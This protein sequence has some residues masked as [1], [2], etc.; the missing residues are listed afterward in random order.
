MSDGW[1]V[2]RDGPEWRVSKGQQTAESKLTIGFLLLPR[3]TLLAFAGFVEALRHSATR[4][5]AFTGSCRWTLLSADQRP[6]TSSCGATV[7]PWQKMTEPERFDYLIVVGGLLTEDIEAD[8]HVLD[9]LRTAAARGVNLIGLCTGSFVLAE[10]GLLQG[11]RCCVHWNH[12]LEFLSRYPDHQIVTDEIFVVD[13]NMVTCAGGSGS[14]D[15]AVWLIERRF[16]RPRAYKTLRHMLT[17]NPR[18]PHHPQPH[19]YS[20][21]PEVKDLRVRRAVHLLERYI[22]NPLKVG[23]LAA[24]VNLSRRQLER[25]FHSAFG[26]GPAEFARR[27]RLDYANW[28]VHYSMQSITDIALACGFSDGAHL[29]RSYRSHFGQTP[30]KARQTREPK[31]EPML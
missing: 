28:L 27:M 13:G 2:G 6:V 25:A 12:Y 23:E 8:R 30:S 16:G 4:D 18:P 29:S 10:A 9:F 11:R 21:L 7:S 3:F 14:I 17:D 24:H 31:T 15:L 22:D 5:S 19:F 1:A 20:A 26:V